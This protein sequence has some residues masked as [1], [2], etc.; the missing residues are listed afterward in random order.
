MKLTSAEA[1][2]ELKVSQRQVQRHARARVVDVEHV[3]GRTLVAGRSLRALERAHARGRRWNERTV[4]AALELFER[5]STTIVE[6][7][8]RSRLKARL[9]ALDLGAIAH[10]M[11][12]G[13]VSFWRPTAG[14]RTVSGGVAIDELGLSASGSLGVEIVEDATRAGRAQ[15]LV[16]DVE[17]EIALVE[18][19]HDHELAA[20]IIALYALGDE[21]EHSAAAG[22]LA[23]RQTSL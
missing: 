3:A 6:G 17:G 2:R 4:R 1:A 15:R 16:R 19:G 11:L 10:Q 12:A 21:R 20:S 5:G 22:W 23:R 14:A 13:R 7:T 8:E 18:L 9:R